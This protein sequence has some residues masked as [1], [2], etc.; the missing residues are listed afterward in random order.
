[1]MRTR[2]IALFLTGNL[3]ALLAQTLP[4]DRQAVR[5]HLNTVKKLPLEQLLPQLDSL[6]SLVTATFGKRDTL[7]ADINYRRAV[8]HLKNGD[9]EVAAKWFK[10][11]L[12]IQ[13]HIYK[14]PQQDIPKT[15]HNLGYCYTK[16]KNYS[17]AIRYLQLA[18]DGRKQNND[19]KLFRSYAQ[20]ATVYEEQGDYS[21]AAKY[22]QLGINSIDQNPAAAASLLLHLAIAKTDLK[23]YAQAKEHIQTAIDYYRTQPD[24]RSKWRLARAYQLRADVFDDQQQYAKA[25]DNYQLAESI[26]LRLD[27]SETL[28]SL[29]NNIGITFRKMGDFAK[30]NDYL[31]RALQL[32]QQLHKAD[33]HTSYVSTYDN[34]GDN[35]AAQQDYYKALSFYDKAIQ[36]NIRPVFP[37]GQMNFTGFDSIIVVGNNAD[38]LTS[39]FSKAKTLTILSQKENNP[40]LIDKSLDTY[41][42]CS[43]LIDKMRQEQVEETSKL[44][45]R[46]KTRPIYEGAIATAS[47]ARRDDLAFG[48]LEKSKAVLLLD[49]L[50]KREA[51]RFIPDSLASRETALL[52]QITDLE[53]Q[54]PTADKSTK[55][56]LLQQI[57]HLRKEWHL[58]VLN[59]ET[60]YPKYH[61][62]KFD[63]KTADIP[64]IQRDLLND[65]TSLLAYSVTADSIYIFVIDKTNTSLTTLKKPNDLTDQVDQLLHFLRD[66]NELNT[67][68]GYANFVALSHRLYE[69]LLKPISDLRPRLYI[70]PDGVLNFV[71]FDVLCTSAEANQPAFLVNNHSVSYGYSATTLLKNKQL[72]TRAEKGL[73][74]VAPERFPNSQLPPLHQSILEVNTLLDITGGDALLE[75][76]ATLTTVLRAA[77]QYR[78]LHLSTHAS[79]NVLAGSPWIAFYDSI[80]YL[81]QI[82]SLPL[83]AELVVLSA[84]ETALGD[85]NQ[86]EG[87]MSL[88][89]GFAYAGVPGTLTTL[90]EIEE[91]ATAEL[92]ASF[93]NYLNEGQ[94]H[95][96]ALHRAKSDYIKT[97]PASTPFHWGALVHIGNKRTTKGL[98]RTL[99][100]GFYDKWFPFIAIGVALIL[101]LWLKIRIFPS[102]SPG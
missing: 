24:D 2:L 9:F 60:Q 69:L 90:W 80:L 1:M 58:F 39:L 30:A 34:M 71:P 10:E 50:K 25:L 70:L 47:L 22:Y 49:A 68:D 81:P 99:T 95:D 84:C 52:A 72:N 102:Q 15:A 87:V 83:K 61:Q 28:S 3:I 38:L 88:A 101:I 32:K 48:F 92:L 35:Y 85:L 53:N 82:Y 31:N 62:Y 37:E 40:D 14:T 7:L 54:L 64:I 91:E 20:M 4:T 66:K 45:W 55:A 89:R 29:Y 97:H 100:A 8:G 63:T 44:F 93:Y 41:L 59:W 21:L 96:I 46:T 13:Q 42:A 33:I 77:D 23:Q 57:I 18:I 11:S 73:L 94:P 6:Q 79:A 5:Q 78:L 27:E 19:P 75:D 36:C 86:G 43:S 26:Y 51:N 67:T 76:Q 65:S 17:Q 98:K 16:T 12:E 56:H 74:A